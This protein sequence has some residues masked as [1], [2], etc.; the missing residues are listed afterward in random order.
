[1]GPKESFAGQQRTICA[2]PESA[3]WLWPL[4]V[5]LG[6]FYFAFMGCG[7]GFSVVLFAALWRG[8]A[9]P[10]PRFPPKA[11]RD[12]MVIPASRVISSVTPPHSVIRVDP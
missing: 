9:L 10:P 4:L 3:S 7:D 2:S 8:T 1:M 5:D 12:H 6:P 11:P